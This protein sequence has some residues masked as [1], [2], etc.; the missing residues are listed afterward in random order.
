[1]AKNYYDI[2]GVPKNASKEDIKKAFRKLAHEY[3]PDKKGGNEEKFKEVNEAYSILSDDSKRAQYDTYGSGF[4]SGGNSGFNPNDFSGFDFS[5]FTQGNG[6][7]FE[8][9]LGDIFGDFF[10]NRQTKRTPRGKDISMDVEISFEESVFGAEKDIKLHT[11][12]K[13]ELCNGSGTKKGTSFDTCTICNGKGKIQEIRRSIIGSFSTVRTC[14]ECLGTGK[15]PKEKCSTCKGK[16]ILKKDRIIKVRIPAGIENGEIVRVHE[17]GEAI[18]A[19]N[20]GD[21]YIKV[22]VKEHPLFEK[23]GINLVMNLSIKVSDAILGKEIP[24]QTLDG[25]INLKIPE[26]TQFGEIL[27]IKGKGIPY[28]TNNRGDLLIRVIIDIP[29]KTSRDVKKIVED[30]REKGV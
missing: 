20:S 21:L 11:A 25:T 6:Q 13:C 15:I 19:G 7:G 27:R 28:G 5:Q 26:G 22:H 2:L 24:I 4:Q 16:G 3:H 17:M 29:K 9:D 30:L 12:I 1:M 10:G 8:F 14:E 18:Q 23:E